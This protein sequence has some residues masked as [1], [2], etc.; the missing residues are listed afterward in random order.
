MA[1]LERVGL[2]LVAL[3]AGCSG[4]PDA[5]SSANTEPSDCARPLRLQAPTF[6]VAPGSEAFGHVVGV[7]SDAGY[8]IRIAPFFDR[9]GTVV[10][11]LFLQRNVPD[12]LQP[13]EA[14][15]GSARGT[16]PLELPADVGVPLPAGQQLELTVHAANTSSAPV[17]VEAGVELCLSDSVTNPA[18][19]VVFGPD[20]FVIPADGAEHAFSSNCTVRGE[21][22]LFMVWP[23]MHS[24][25]R[26]IDVTLDTE[27]LASVPDWDVAEQMLVPLSPPRPA[28]DGQLLGVECVY[29]NTGTSDVSWGAHS[30]DE[31]C[32]AYVYYYP[33]L[34]PW[35]CS[36]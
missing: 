18:D 10:H 2:A 33:A 28:S 32:F 3:V 20:H 36:G 13:S 7:V 1:A 14:L 5:P 35:V 11:H 9:G 25:G 29:L 15:F 19:V 17:E 30:S 21:R 8:V 22:S 26:R 16:P 27:T 12:A 24:L 34:E 4:T 6:S 23:H 31:M